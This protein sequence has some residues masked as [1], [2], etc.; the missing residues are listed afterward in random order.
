M[1]FTENFL[2]A[3]VLVG[4]LLPLIALARRGAVERTHLLGLVLVS[5][6]GVAAAIQR[7]ERDL[8]LELSLPVPSGAEG[9]R[10]SS[11]CRGCHP[12]AYDSWHESFH[13]TMTQPAGPESVVAPFDGR[14]LQARGRAFVVERRDDELWVTQVEPG[15]P[16]EAREL[17]PAERVVM[18]TG[19]RHAQIYWTAAADG[20]LVQVPWVYVIA[21]ERWVPM[22]DSFLNPGDSTQPRAKWNRD[23]MRCHSVGGR[24]QFDAEAGDWS[25]R[26]TELGIACAG[27]H[28]PAEEHIRSHRNPLHRQRMRASGGPDP[29]IVNPKRLTQERS[30]AVCGQCH[31]FATRPVGSYDEAWTSFRAGNELEGHFRITVGGEDKNS[32]WPDGAGRIGGREYN[33]MTL[34]ACYTDGEMTCLS[35]HTMHGDDPRDQLLPSMG[36][37][38]ACLQC[39]GDFRDRI[40]EHTFHEAASSGSRCLS[41]HMPYTGYALLGAVRMHYVDSPTASG[42]TTRDRPNACNLCH[43]DRTLEWAADELAADLRRAFSGIV[44]GNVKEDG[45]R[46][47]EEF[48]PFEIHGEPA[49]MQALD[50]LLR[51]FV[52]QRRMKIAGE[53]R[54]CYRVVT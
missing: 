21:D 34:S 25:T 45:M 47:I 20:S 36:G 3:V 14:T 28:G 16:R 8:D 30:A 7:P 12:G 35:C 15:D 2:F 42:R 31:A 53:Y 13:R 5:L 38:E 43:L 33:T 9:M 49:M 23:C 54:P 11:T 40:A 10:S 51:A 41:C 6:V 32:F 24:P 26:V 1:H 19:S 29:T 37:D 17:A 22:E 50:A 27:C 18:T 48:G 52:E 44:A 39:H 4:A 46:R